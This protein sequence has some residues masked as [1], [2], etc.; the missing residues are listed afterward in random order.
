MLVLVQRLVA[1][2]RE[3]DA[4]HPDV[5][6]LEQHLG[7]DSGRAAFRILIFFSGMASPTAVCTEGKAGRRYKINRLKSVF[8]ARSPMC[9]ST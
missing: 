8:L 6:V 3:F 7:A 9:F 4:P 1:L 5:L 2:A